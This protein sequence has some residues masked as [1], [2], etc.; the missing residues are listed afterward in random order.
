MNK[1]DILILAILLISTTIGLCKGFIKEAMSLLFFI[2]SCYVSILY[3]PLLYLFISKYI[4]DGIVCNIFSY[5]IIFFLV[6]ILLGL[7]NKNLL[8]FIKY[9]GF[10]SIDH[11][12]GGIFGAIRGILILSM[13][14]F[15]INMTPIIYELW[16]SNSLFIKLINQLNQFLKSYYQ[17]YFLI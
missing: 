4:N 1:L 15:I 10:S 2:L 17:I 3:S 6:I 5:L 11:T 16:W 13:I 7:I 9:S 12:L 14:I 8:I